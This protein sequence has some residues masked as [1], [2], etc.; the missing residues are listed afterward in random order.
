[1]STAPLTSP[2]S[3]RHIWYR[4]SLVMGRTIL[5]NIH[6]LHN[7]PDVL[8]KDKLKHIRKFQLGDKKIVS[9][10]PLTAAGEMVCP[11]T[12][13]KGWA[14]YQAVGCDSWLRLGMCQ[15][16]GLGR[17]C[18]TWQR[19]GECAAWEELGKCT[20]W[21]TMGKRSASWQLEEGILPD[22]T[23][24]RGAAYMYICMYK[25]QIYVCV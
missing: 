14:P 20:S 4:H 13:G 23:W 18:A 11:L 12:Q 7:M 22:R 6:T 2:P 10:S 9:S 15:L 3:Q 16:K 21:V 5:R 17:D 19:L 1:M 8:S 24:E 25:V